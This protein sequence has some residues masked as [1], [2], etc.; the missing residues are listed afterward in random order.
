LQEHPDK[1]VYVSD[2][3]LHPVHNTQ[4]GVLT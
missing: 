1:G 2:I 3:S 4:V